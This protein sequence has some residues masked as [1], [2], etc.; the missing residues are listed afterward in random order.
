ML[1]VLV[2]LLT[3]TKPSCSIDQLGNP[4][5]RTWGMQDGGCTS[6]A[7]PCAAQH[8]IRPPLPLAGCKSISSMCIPVHASG[9]VSEHSSATAGYFSPL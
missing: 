6:L 8:S 7:V 5:A 1:V 2:V 4:G 3:L 9:Q